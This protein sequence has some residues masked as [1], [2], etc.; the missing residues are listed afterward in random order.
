MRVSVGLET[1]TLQKLY[2]GGGEPPNLRPYHWFSLHTASRSFDFGVK[3]CG[4]DE[5]ETLVL[6]VF[7]L[8]QLLFAHGAP[9]ARASPAAYSALSHAQAQWQRYA[10][11]AKECPLPPL[12]RTPSLHGRPSS[13]TDLVPYSHPCRWQGRA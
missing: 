3:D 2:T 12:K 7:T 11:A 10:S 9:A 5:S 13:R 8:Q 1:R 6:W 4:A